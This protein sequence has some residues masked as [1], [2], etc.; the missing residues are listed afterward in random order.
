MTNLFVGQSPLI[1]VFGSVFIFVFLVKCRHA[2][3]GE[4]PPLKSRLQ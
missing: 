4:F 1:V 2:K 3:D